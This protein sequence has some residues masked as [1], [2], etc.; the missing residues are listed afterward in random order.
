MSSELAFHKLLHRHEAHS[1]GLCGDEYGRNLHLDSVWLK[2][3]K[4]SLPVP[5][6]HDNNVRG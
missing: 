6:G 2:Y 3:L 4:I 5:R 1:E